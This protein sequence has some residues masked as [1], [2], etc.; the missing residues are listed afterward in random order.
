MQNIRR[1]FKILTWSN[2]SGNWGYEENKRL[3]ISGLLRLLLDLLPN[4]TSSVSAIRYVGGNLD[5]QPKNR[6]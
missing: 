4:L 5:V 3:F 6:R 2:K 1:K